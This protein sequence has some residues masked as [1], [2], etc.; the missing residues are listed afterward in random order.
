MADAIPLDYH[1]IPNSYRGMYM[2]RD[3]KLNEIAAEKEHKE[4]IF[5]T[6][7]KAVPTGIGLVDNRILMWVNERMTE[8]TGYSEQELIEKS[9]RM[10]Y[11]TDEEFERVGKIKYGQIKVNC[12]GSI[13]TR[14]QKKDG[15]LIDVFL[16]TRAFKIEQPTRAIFSALDITEKKRAERELQ[17]LKDE[18][19]RRVEIRTVEF[20]EANEKLLEMNA[21]LRKLTSELAVVEERE[22]RSLAVCLHDN[23]GQ[24][25]A[26]SKMKLDLLAG[27]IENNGLKGLCSEISDEVRESII[28]IRAITRELSPPVLHELSFKESIQWL[29]E[30]MNERYGVNVLFQSEPEIKNPDFDSKVVLFHAAR[31]LILNAVKHARATKIKITLKNEGDDIALNIEDNGIGFNLKTASE[32]KGVGLM[33]LR[34]KIQNIGGIFDIDSSDRGTRAK[35]IFRLLHSDS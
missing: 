15:S 7:M 28:D 32:G 12:I 33:S 30:N 19:E 18:L 10:L 24:R 21:K 9:S 6:T 8:I 5:E 29:A 14:W 31:E 23:V 25:L 17:K 34:E 22:R 2:D 13:E 35:M 26:A 27:M 16:Q 20:S 4:S 11:G 1:F 3:K